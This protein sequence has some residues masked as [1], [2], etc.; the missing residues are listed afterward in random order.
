MIK[1]S[2]V[3]CLLIACTSLYAQKEWIQINTDHGGEYNNLK[4]AIPVVDA[5]TGKFA[6]FLKEKNGITAYYFDDNQELISEIKGPEL[7]KNTP[8]FIGNAIK[9]DRCTLFFKNHLGRPFSSLQ[10]DFKTEKYSL[11]KTLDISLKKETVVDYFNDDDRLY[12]L[13]IVKRTSI[14]KLY[15]INV[16]SEVLVETIDLSKESFS[17]FHSSFYN[18]YYGNYDSDKT[19]TVLFG[20]P[21]SLEIASARSKAYFENGVITLTADFSD[22][23]TY[24]L[25]INVK[26][27]AYSLEEYKNKN[28]KRSELRAKSN[29][30][31]Y[32]AYFFNV[33]TT[34]KRLVLD[35]YDRETKS[36]IKEFKIDEQS[37][38]AFKNTPIILEEGDFDSYRE[39]D[40]NTQFLR[41]ITKSNLG[42]GVYEQ[43][44]NLVLTLGASKEK[45]S[46]GS[47]GL[48]VGAGI[49][50]GIVG[51]ALIGSFGSYSKTKST[52]IIGLFDKNLNHVKGEVPINGFDKI[53]NYTRDFKRIQL[54]S[55][56]KYGDSYIWGCFY[57]S[58][59]TYRFVKF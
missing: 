5:L 21:T 7:P 34:S 6:F 48:I 36:L 49:L 54:E 9:N 37:P 17:D 46:G 55:I 20:E 41:K 45:L 26:D 2:I 40:K 8:V 28:S 42:V 1:R 4:Q 31:I 16:D 44:G 38:I 53:N 24:L 19:T 59:G 51:G 25:N 23:Y 11:K 50:G 43:H 12:V 15:T 39:L 57:K 47:T 52:R 13:S 32:D 35:V 30:F 56:F 18:L 14:L 27:G 58:T 3:F 33:Y 10:F 29:S 22:A